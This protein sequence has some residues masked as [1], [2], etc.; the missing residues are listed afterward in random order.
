M[1]LT[2]ASVINRVG[3]GLS[4]AV[5]GGP[6]EPARD[7]ARDALALPAPGR[8]AACSADGVADEDLAGRAEDGAADGAADGARDDLA[9]EAPECTRLLRRRPLGEGGRSGGGS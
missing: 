6:W 2:L 7:A 1:V 8:G 3:S 5:A 9:E 4:G